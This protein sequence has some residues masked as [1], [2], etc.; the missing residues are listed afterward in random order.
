MKNE[1]N[2]SPNLMKNE[3][4][5][6]DK[7]F[8]IE[9]K[10]LVIQE[11]QEVASP[12]VI[13]V[14]EN[15]DDNVE[16]SCEYQKQIL[17][18]TQTVLETA[19]EVAALTQDPRAMTAAAEIIKALTNASEALAKI[20][21]KKEELSL[22]KTALKE[23]SKKQEAQTINNNAIFIGSTSELQKQIISGLLEKIEKEKN[24]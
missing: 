17:E 16:L 4:N 13:S 23:K 21:L 20:T 12:S 7:I 22:K 19:L 6:L 5:T 8:N 18:K 24:D 11:Q 14:S 15:I 2:G 1:K 10:E 9:N 3:T